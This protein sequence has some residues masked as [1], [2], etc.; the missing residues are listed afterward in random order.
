VS[1][2]PAGARVSMPIPRS[3]RN[4]TDTHQQ[5]IIAH[6]TH[7]ETR[8]KHTRHH[9]HLR[10]TG[11]HARTEMRCVLRVQPLAGHT[12]GMQRISSLAVCL[13]LTMMNGVAAGRSSRRTKRH[14]VGRAVCS[15]V[16]VEKRWMFRCECARRV[17]RGLGSIAHSLQIQRRLCTRR[18]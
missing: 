4:R 8:S 6:E 5:I 1:T 11:T 9:T 10:H 16:W 15:V 12:V 3:L 13:A 17:A 7:T 2:L 18:W 14:L